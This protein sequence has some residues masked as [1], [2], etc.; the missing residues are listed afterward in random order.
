MKIVATMVYNFLLIMFVAN[1]LNFFS[2]LQ[3]KFI[4]SSRPSGSPIIR[5]VIV[6]D[7]K[8]VSARDPLTTACQNGMQAG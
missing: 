2:M 3:S 4:A 8:F 6:W 5:E 7:A 1:S